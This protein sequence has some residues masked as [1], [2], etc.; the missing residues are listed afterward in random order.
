MSM[1]K[2]GRFES[3][4]QNPREERKLPLQVTSVRPL[5]EYVQNG[6]A[7]E[8]SWPFLFLRTRATVQPNYWLSTVSCIAKRHLN[9][10]GISIRG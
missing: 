3:I 10:A 5:A 1:E 6:P 2:K 9:L 8:R 4:L 7:Q